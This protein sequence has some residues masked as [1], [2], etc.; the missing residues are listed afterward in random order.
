MPMMD[1]MGKESCPVC[2]ALAKAVKKKRKAKE[3]LRATK[4]DLAKAKMEQI[5]AIKGDIGSKAPM[6]E[7]VDGGPSRAR[8]PMRLLDDFS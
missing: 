5:Q 7:G 8:C 1:Y 2:P 3:E 4:N 6:D